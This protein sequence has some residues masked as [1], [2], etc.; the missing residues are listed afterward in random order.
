[1]ERNLPAE[2]Y[3]LA[4]QYK[5]G[6][7][8]RMYG[9]DGWQLFSL[10]GSF[11][12]WLLLCASF[13]VMLLLSYQ[14]IIKSSAG[15]IVL[16]FITAALALALLVG[17][18]HIILQRINLFRYARIYMCEHGFIFLD[19]QQQLSIRWDQIERV[20][21]IASRTRLKN[22]M[23][24]IL[25]TD[26]KRINVSTFWNKRLQTLIRYRVT[27]YRNRLKQVYSDGS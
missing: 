16:G 2:A 27:L 11:A 25:L 19:K 26:G 18:T 17:L 1:M 13:I 5:L 21:T 6:S 3:Q 22:E 4:E 15:L 8:G 9:A 23:C 14:G 7:P 24:Q 20:E 12:S 10:L